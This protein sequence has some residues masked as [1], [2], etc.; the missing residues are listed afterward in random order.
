MNFSFIGSSYICGMGI[1]VILAQRFQ[2]HVRVR[3]VSIS[4]SVG[5]RLKFSTRR[6]VRRLGR[7]RLV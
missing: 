7:L 3:N 1:K 2:L 6:R 4:A 5:V